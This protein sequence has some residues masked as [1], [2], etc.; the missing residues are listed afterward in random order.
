MNTSRGARA[1]T[2]PSVLHV[3]EAAGTARQLL[4]EAHRR[5][6]RWDHLPLADP[7]LGW[8]GPLAGA[9][10]GA[11][12]VSWLVRL[13][14][15]A[16]RRDIVHIHSAATF[17]HSRY[18]VRR[19]V[20]H[21]HGTDVR[22]AQYEPGLGPVVRAALQIAERV[23]YSTPDLAE[24]VL[25]R[26]ADATYFPVPI[27]VGR[28]PLWS[29]PTRPR[30][31]FASRWEAVKGLERQLGVARSLR[32]AL[33]EGA[34][35]VG[36]DWGPAAAE[37][38]AAGVELVPRL[39]H[40]AYLGWLAGATAVIGQASGILSASELEALGTGAPLLLPVPLPLYAEDP[41]P[42]L[43]HDIESVVE[44]ARS[45]VVGAPHDAAAGHAWVER[46]HGTG[47]AVDTLCSLYADV[48]ATRDR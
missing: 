9:Q 25:G 36:L 46:V 20:L 6:L 33:G 2:D 22:T 45:L 27:E 24:H 47:Q 37:A 30:V 26:R 48:L 7:D 39:G 29:R 5:G 15:L 38:R 34:Q 41:P 16:S 3:G 32:A 19:F 17:G 40:A 13:R 43:G 14:M 23:L 18:A 4:D 21:C 10:R 1:V 35:I 44:I 42:V 11:R 31:V 28:L 8:P 12:G